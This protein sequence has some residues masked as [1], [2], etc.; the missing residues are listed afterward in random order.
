MRCYNFWLNSRFRSYLYLFPSFASEYLELPR[1]LKVHVFFLERV[2][3]F[4]PAAAGHRETIRPR[5]TGRVQARWARLA[6][7]T[8]VSFPAPGTIP[9]VV[10]LPPWNMEICQIK[11]KL[12]VLEAN[13]CLP[14]SR[15]ARC[16]PAPPSSLFFLKGRGENWIKTNHC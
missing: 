2:E 14:A 15:W 1:L 4:S 12:I 7:V 16:L 13:L 5:G 8:S 3:C 6:S 9:A 10:T 11:T